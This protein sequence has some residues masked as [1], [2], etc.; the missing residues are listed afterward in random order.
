MSSG[1][2]RHR[3]QLRGGGG[4]PAAAHSHT[5]EKLAPTICS[6]I[7]MKTRPMMIAIEVTTLPACVTGETSPYPTWCG[8]R[9]G[10]SAPSLGERPWVG[11][12]Q[13]PTVEKVT[14][15]NQTAWPMSS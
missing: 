8:P 14:I 3:L 11:R 10:V 12:G 1:V 9:A 7:A 15:M 13:P 5:E 4:G 2:E 6:G